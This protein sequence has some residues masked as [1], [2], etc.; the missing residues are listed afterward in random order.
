[1]TPLLPALLN[2]RARLLQRVA[3]LEARR[4]QGADVWGEYLTTLTALTAVAGELSPERSGRLL[5]TSELAERLNV[6]ERT[7]RR[8]TRKGTMAPALKLGRTVRW[9]GAS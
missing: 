7:I 2:A 4:D 6:S 8:R 3:D 1:M 9:R 5:T